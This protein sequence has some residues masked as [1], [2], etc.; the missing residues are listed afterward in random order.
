[1]VLHNTLASKITI[2]ATCHLAYISRTFTHHL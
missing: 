1:L 2:P